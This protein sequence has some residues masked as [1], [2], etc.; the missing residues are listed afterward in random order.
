MSASTL[1][2]LSSLPHLVIL[3]RLHHT[4]PKV[5]KAK[6][7]LSGDEVRSDLSY[8]RGSFETSRSLL[9]PVYTS[10]K[11]LYYHGHVF[12]PLTQVRFRR[13]DGFVLEGTIHYCRPSEVSFYIDMSFFTLF[14][15][16]FSF[17]PCFPPVYLWLVRL[18]RDFIL[19][20]SSP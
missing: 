1:T 7:G 10:D 12:K 16:P 5:K 8:M 2:P 6:I 3:L 9:S 13:K 11:S 14:M 4:G 17:Y 20:L 15:A 19:S 18:L